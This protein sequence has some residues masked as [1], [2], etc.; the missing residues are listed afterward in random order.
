MEGGG[1]GV[2]DD[3]TP[4]LGH[5]AGGEG[6]AHPIGAHRID[7]QGLNPALGVAGGDALQWPEDAGGIDQNGRGAK[8]GLDLAFNGFG[9]CGGADIGGHSQGRAPPLADVFCGLTQLFDR[10]G[11]QN[12]RG[13]RCGQPA[14]GLLA[15]P[16]A[17]ASDYRDPST[18]CSLHRRS[19]LISRSHWIGI[20]SA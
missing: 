8:V 16:P 19:F 6:P 4:T 7:G 18:Q 13:P 15:E 2:V 17:G 3:P 14:G 11:D 1:R 12:G 10:A 20:I 9:P 5:H